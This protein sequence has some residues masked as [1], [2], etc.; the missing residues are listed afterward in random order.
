MYKVSFYEPILDDVIIENCA[1]EQDAIDKANNLEAQGFNHVKIFCV[2]DL[3]ETK[4]V[5]ITEYKQM[6]KIR[7]NSDY[8]WSACNPTIDKRLII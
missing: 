7:G 2:E 5:L 4:R 3:P 6:K 1:N 8:F